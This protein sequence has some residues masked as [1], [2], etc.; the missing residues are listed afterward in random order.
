MPACL[1]KEKN[2]AVISGITFMGYLDHPNEMIPDG[3]RRI[4]FLC[5]DST[6]AASLPTTAG[7]EL[8]SGAV[9]AKPAPGSLAIVRGGDDLWLGTD[10]TWA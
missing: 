2:M 5:D 1:R 7:L 4:L 6:A 9:T 3:K 10:G 8:A